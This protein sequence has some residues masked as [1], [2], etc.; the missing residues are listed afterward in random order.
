[1]CGGYMGIKFST[2]LMRHIMVAFQRAFVEPK[3][4][5]KGNNIGN[6]LSSHNSRTA[7]HFYAREFDN[8]EGATT[9]YL[10]DVQEWCD[11]YHD[12]IGLGERRGPL[13]PLQTKRK[14]A[15]QLVT[16]GTMDSG[17]TLVIN[18]KL[19]VL[20]QLGETAYRAGLQESKSH[21]AK[22]IFEAVGNGFENLISDRAIFFHSLLQDLIHPPHFPNHPITN[23]PQ[24]QQLQQHLSKQ[25][26]GKDNFL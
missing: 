17:D 7:D 13:V 1:M 6:L 18:V 22:E 19:D 24:L 15:Q 25:S 16:I 4:V 26:V 11:L 21:A 9:N 2:Q 14:I 10:L 5:D 3:V 23:K 20:K 8:L 12:A